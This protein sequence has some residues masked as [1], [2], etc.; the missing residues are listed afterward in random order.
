MTSI[1][2][3][4]V[5]ATDGPVGLVD[6]VIGAV[7]TDDAGDAG[8]LVVDLV[9]LDLGVKRAV[10]ATAVRDVDHATETVALR[11]E[12]D[13]VSSAPEV[14]PDLTDTDTLLDKLVRHYFG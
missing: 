1:V 3:F 9:D 11:C 2:G 7:T 14:K 13:L 6:D 10:P 4:K 5:V 8:F 12:R